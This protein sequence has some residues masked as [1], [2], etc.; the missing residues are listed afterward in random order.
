M[1]PH[2]A[3]TPP[4]DARLTLV[5]LGGAALLRATDGQEPRPELGPGK[6]LALLTYL[7]WSPGRSAGREE[8]IDLL[9][10]DLP[11]DRARAALRQIV[12]QIRHRLGE[13]VLSS[14]SDTLVLSVPYSADRDAFLQAVE[15]GALEVAV[16]QYT[17]DFFPSF[18]A[19]GAAEF[20]KWADRQRDQLRDLFL[21][22]AGILVR[23]WLSAAR[24]RDAQALARRG[25]DATPLREGARRLLLEALVA[26][27][28]FVTAAVE[29]DDLERMLAEEEREPEPAT[30]E[31]IR[32]A[33]R[34]L[35]EGGDAAAPAPLA[36]ELIGRERE[37]SAITAA[38]NE[39]RLRGGQHVHVVA[40][41]GIGKTRLLRDLDRRL[42]TLH[43][44]VVHVRSN[45]GERPVPYTL[46]AKLAE[47]LAKLRG[48]AGISPAAAAS[49]V[50]LSPSLSATYNAAPDPFPSS[51]DDALRRRTTAVGELVVAVA[52]NRP[53]VILVDDLHWSDTASRL[54]VQGVLGR[55]SEGHVL[56]VTAARPEPGG[57][58]STSDTVLLELKPL[59]KGGVA[60]LVASL[61]ALPHQE[62]ADWLADELDTATGGSPLLVLETLQLALERGSLVRTEH[63]WQ[64]PDPDALFV[65]LR[66]GG[67]LRHRITQLDPGARRLLLLLALAGAPLAAARLARAVRADVVLVDSLLGTLEQRGLAV[68][69]GAEWQPAHDEIASL[70]R[71]STEPG[72][73]REECAVL[74]RVFAEDA[75]QDSRLLRRAAALLAAGGDDKDLQDVYNRYVAEAHRRGDRRAASILATELLGDHAT[76]TRVARLVVGL[77][78]RRRA[79]LDSP[80]RVATVSALGV[81]AIAAMLAFTFRSTAEADATLLVIGTGRGGAPVVRRAPLFRARWGERDAVEPTE[82]DRDYPRALLDRSLAPG[83]THPD[84]QRWLVTR[85]AADSGGQDVWLVYRSG[86][87]R[88]LTHAPGDDGFA[89]WSPDGRMAVFRTDRW[90]FGRSRAD[91][92]ILDTATL[93]VRLLTGGREWDGDPVWSPDG[94]RIAFVRMFFEDPRPNHLCWTTVEG[95]PP[96]CTEVQGVNAFRIG[97]W[98]DSQNV[99]ATADSGGTTA[100]VR[101]NVGSGQVRYVGTGN[102]ERWMS[103]DGQWVACRCTRAGFRGLSWFVFPVDRPDQTKPLAVKAEPFG[104]L[105][106]RWVPASRPRPYLDT[107]HVEEPPNGV[108]ADAR[109]Q[110]RARGVDQYGQPIGVHALRWW[111]G[112]TSV[113][114]I[115]S[116]GVLESRRVG[117]AVVHAS[118]GG[119]RVDSATIVIRPPSYTVALREGWRDSPEARWVPFGEPRPSLTTGPG[120][121]RA[122][123]NAGDSTWDSGAY[124]R[125]RFHAGAGFGL[126][127]TLS[128]PMTDV[129]WQSLVIS[130]GPARDSSE[131]A[132]WDHRNGRYDALDPDA[133]GGCLVQYPYTDGAIG[134]NGLRVANGVLRRVFE[135]PATYGTGTWYTVRLQLFPDGRCGFAVDGKPLWISENELP[136]HRPFRVVLQGRSYNTRMLVGPLQAW[137]GVRSDIDWGVLDSTA[138]SVAAAPRR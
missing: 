79:G 40:P 104:G 26:G 59:G 11:P 22:A 92:A 97:A 67:A 17:G 68:R 58:P 128:S 83:V 5:T 64:C 56:I 99:L 66:A 134:R 57:G 12:W 93:E 88:R 101:I 18:A 29:A 119:W 33:R 124:S 107:L 76:P 75:E 112:D 55:V 42:R 77:P 122:F 62:W 70:T 35:P 48:S 1:A 65:E 98:Y 13:G 44:C 4:V 45:P 25:R 63:G 129:Q 121:V 118:A 135:V 32:L 95:A 94:A 61:G 106:V 3:P 20:E 69:V 120:G 71:D 138:V 14:G 85:N 74:G 115:D 49:L 16:R 132:A 113:A 53:L 80:A 36:A 105:R 133:A 34:M 137:E 96:R 81:A 125:A 127:T 43:A 51:G 116:A 10:A 8:L 39:G 21:H 78:L 31:A 30:L 2:E 102:G 87:E 73:L 54:L 47:A 130:V 23:R 89:A 84:G 15:D 6:A 91:I 109:H 126:E 52:E 86:R 41:P 24:F 72:V 82:I 123:W 28:E 9:W 136:V 103:P 27:G 110:L 111:S 117:R 19:P 108:P 7:A 100:L 38:W 60:A 46:A 50:A 131:M 90:G 37:F 114:R